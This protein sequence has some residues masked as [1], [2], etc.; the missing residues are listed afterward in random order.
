MSQ[1]P[2]G[3]VSFNLQRPRHSVRLT[4]RPNAVLRV[5]RSLRISHN[6]FLQA[7]KWIL[8]LILILS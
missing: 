7:S 2:R 3:V 5:L 6:K 1:V 8:T 4:Y